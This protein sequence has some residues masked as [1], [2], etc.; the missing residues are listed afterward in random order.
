MLVAAIS[1]VLIAV[2]A[3]FITIPYAIATERAMVASNSLHTGP[4]RCR[5][6]RAMLRAS[7]TTDRITIITLLTRVRASIATISL[8]GAAVLIGAVASGAHKPLL[9]LTA[10]AAS[11]AVDLVPIVALLL[12]DPAAITTHSST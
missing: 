11:I 3:A 2:V 1:R 7:V 6:H 5:L 4:T 12:A 9:H 8:R 10:H